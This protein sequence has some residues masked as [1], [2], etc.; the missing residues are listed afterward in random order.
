MT[1]RCVVAILVPV[2]GRPHRVEPLMRNVGEATPTLHRLV[3]IASA[4]D[5][6]ELSELERCGADTIGVDWPGGSSGDYARKINAGYRAT[7]EPLL[8]QGADDLR[9]HSGWLEEAVRH[10]SPPIAVVGTNDLHSVRVRGEEYSTHSLLTRAYVERYGTID[11][12]GQV[13]H[14]GYPHAF[15]DDEFVGTARFRG[16]FRYA[17]DSIVEH[18]HPD[19]GKG[20]LDWVY[21][22]GGSRY[23]E[24]QALFEARQQQW[25]AMPTNASVA[26]RLPLVSVFTPTWETGEAITVPYE[27]LRRQTYTNW[28]WVVLD[29]SETADTAAALAQLGNRAP[30][31]PAVRVYRQEP[32]SGSIGANKAAAAALAHGDILVELDHDDELAPDALEIIAATFVAHPEVDFVF[33]DFVDWLDIGDSEGSPALYPDGWAFGFGAYATEIIDGRRVPVGLSPPITPETIR[34]IVAAPNHVRAWR[35]TFYR[36][37]GGHNFHL[38][39]ADDY[40]LVVRTFLEGTMARVP[41]P[42]YVQHH[43]PHGASASRRRNEEIQGRVQDLARRYEFDIHER[44]LML[45]VTDSA[46][47]GR[48]WTDPEPIVTASVVLDP[49]VEAA[50][51]LERPLVSVVIPTYRRPESLRDAIDSVL[52]QSYPYF[53]VLVVGDCCPFVDTVVAAVGDER[54]RHWNLADHYGDGGASPRNYAL[55]AMARGTLIAYLDDDNTW[56]SDHLESM[57]TLLVAHPVLTFAFSSLEIDGEPIICRRPRRYQIDTSALVHHRFLL[58]RY[59]YWRSQADVGYAH[60]WELVSRWKGEPWVPSLEPTVRYRLGGGDEQERA[61]AELRCVAAEEMDRVLSSTAAGDRDA[62]TEDR[63]S[64]PSVWCPSPHWWH[65]DDERSPEREVR[66][67]IGALVRL[68]QPGFV[69]EVSAG[70][71][72]TSIEIGDALLANGH[73]HADAIEPDAVQAARARE[74]VGPLPVRILVEDGVTYVPAHPVDLA[75]LASLPT[76]D[77]TLSVRQVFEWLAPGGLL[78]LPGSARG[79]VE[80]PDL[81]GLA[82]VRLDLPT[83][84]GLQLL[85]R[86]QL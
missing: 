76:S 22:R 69:L 16:M 32:P 65:S 57:V 7:D 74:R 2:L 77:G 56:R 11:K 63:F 61:L 46:T 19:A 21:E 70:E 44:M 48:P 86:T 42:L 40:D 82:C 31:G 68:L 73:G 8:F 20:P 84:R 71:G 17:P 12:P 28:E 81:D 50:A 47:A 75:V 64:P 66:G 62:P 39:V 41:R 25:S 1:G 37:I 14:Q 45:G 10:L 78:V 18:L 58:D 60:D 67:F 59:G 51:E 54:V 29:D 13:L 33:S 49:V 34:H 30:D 27:S 55:K 26:E 5:A 85:Q 36:R 35:T 83:P 52:S 80:Q 9:F 38:P 6:E 23:R 4:D 3:F 53:E 15:C 79:R 24:A 43:S 72:L